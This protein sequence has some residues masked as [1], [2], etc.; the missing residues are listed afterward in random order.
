MEYLHYFLPTFVVIV[1]AIIHIEVNIATVKNDIKWIKSEL[2][3]K[4]E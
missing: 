3:K 1:G 4:G 2:N